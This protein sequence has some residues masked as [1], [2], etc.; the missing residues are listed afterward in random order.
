MTAAQDE[1]GRPNT[2]AASGQKTS[3]HPLAAPA[4]V[5]GVALVLRMLA[6]VA[7]QAFVA[8][9]GRNRLCVFPD[10]EYYWALAQTIR[11]G[12]TYEIVE[13]GTISHKA[14]RTP[15]YPIFLAACHAVLG[16][17]PLGVRVV[18]AVLGTASVGL[19]YLLTVRCAQRSMAPAAGRS[20]SR[21]AAVAAATLA[22]INPYYV[23]MS[24]LLLS[25][26]IF[27]PLLLAT[28]WGLA[29]LWRKP[30]EP[31]WPATPA[32]GLIALA[33]GAAGGAAVL[34]RPSFALFL[35]AV[36][37]GWLCAVSFLRDRR[38]LKGAVASAIIFAVGVV[39]VMSP[40]WIRNARTYG[41]FVP[42]SIWLGA[43]LY[44]G[45][46]PREPAAVPWNSARILI[47]A[48]SGRWSRTAR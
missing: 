4:A 12:R 29:I 36:L 26:A 19:V 28:I 17:S 37:F 20:L 33:S 3:W 16:E 32:R 34:A 42:T 9:I 21:T 7:L 1:P 35:P 13:W 15:A 22:A 45:L 47:Y 41:R 40:W 14:M 43:S 5:L 39:L 30:D 25:E 11:Q 44:D 46:N 8:R 2:A 27:I 6:A 48:C 10:T 18:Q 24:E 23:A 38:L 31:D